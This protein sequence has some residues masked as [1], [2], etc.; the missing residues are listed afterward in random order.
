LLPEIYSRQD[1][2]NISGLM[3]TERTIPD[4]Q[5][6][7]HQINFGRGRHELKKSCVVGI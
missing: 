7:V 6:V 2:A 1:V 3:L 5:L 4:F